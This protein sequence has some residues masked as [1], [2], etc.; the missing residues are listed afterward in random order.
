VRAAD[1]AAVPVTLT[2]T[3]MSAWTTKRMSAKSLPKS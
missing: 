1:T 2:L 3:G